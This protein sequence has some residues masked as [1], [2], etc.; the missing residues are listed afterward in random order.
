M[1]EKCYFTFLSEEIF[2]RGKECPENY[3]SIALLNATLVILCIQV[4]KYQQP[5]KPTSPLKYNFLPCQWRI[6]I[7]VNFYAMLNF[8]QCKQERLKLSIE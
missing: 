6:M 8:F 1:R 2:L 3:T 7:R 5:K 4:F